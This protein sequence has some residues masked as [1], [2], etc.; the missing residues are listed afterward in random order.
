MSTLVVSNLLL[1]YGSKAQGR[2]LCSSI[3]SNSLTACNALIMTKR[4]IQLFY[5]SILNTLAPQLSQLGPIHMTS[6]L[7]HRTLPAMRMVSGKYTGQGLESTFNVIAD[8]GR[9]NDIQREN[10]RSLKLHMVPDTWR[11]AMKS[12]SVGFGTD[13]GHELRIRSQ[14]NDEETIAQP[15]TKVAAA[16]TATITQNAQATG[17]ITTSVIGASTTTSS[18]WDV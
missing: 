11:D 17:A 18:S 6:I 15:V 2:F 13:H 7:L 12:I 5:I 14:V 3:S 16:E 10:E 8:K 1:P 4:S 9:V